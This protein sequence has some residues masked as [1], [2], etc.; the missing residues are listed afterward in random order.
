MVID[1]TSDFHPVTRLRKKVLKIVWLQKVLEVN[2]FL[3]TVYN[4]Y[5]WPSNAVWELEW[6]ITKNDRIQRFI[7]WINL[8]LLSPLF[9]ELWARLMWQ[10]SNYPPWWTM[11]VARWMCKLP[12]MKSNGG[13]LTTAV[14]CSPLRLGQFRGKIKGNGPWRRVRLW[15]G[16]FNILSAICRSKPSL[17]FSPSLSSLNRKKIRQQWQNC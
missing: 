15:E 16:Q 8:V 1:M 4:T 17:P 3:G 7:F 11:F 6:K 13:A 5:I 2:V 14:T 12:R 10:D 9:P